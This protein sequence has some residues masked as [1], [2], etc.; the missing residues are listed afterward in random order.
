MAAGLRSARTD[1]QASLRGRLPQDVLEHSRRAYYAQ[2]AHIDNQIG[3][4]L[5]SFR[6]LK[7]DPPA[8]IFTSD[9][10]E[11]LGDHNLFRKTWAYEGSAAV[12]LLMQIPGREGV[13]FC[14]APN[15]SHDVYPTI[16]DIAGVDAP[17]KID[18]KSLLHFADDPGSAD[19]REYVH[20][21]HSACYCD[22]DGMQYLTDGKEKYIWWSVT[23]AE[24]FFDL[25]T[26]PYELTDLSDDPAHAE[27]VDAWRQRL[28]KELA[29]REEDGL[30]D[31]R[32]LITGKR[33]P[34]VRA[35]MAKTWGK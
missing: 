26:D 35:E 28:V 14:D 21:E 16:L 12:P 30:S 33:L 25:R 8:I 1:A 6:R 29:P 3:R 13:E 17:G 11:M 7:I 32:K 2:I 5:L 20:G 19:R 31:G 23:G 22:G 24:Q 4:V 18:G 10:G 15:I 34:A 27:R 9:H